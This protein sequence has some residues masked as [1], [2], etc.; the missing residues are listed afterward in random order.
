MRDRVVS[1][2]LAIGRYTNRDEAPRRPKCPFTRICADICGIRIAHEGS[3]QL[4]R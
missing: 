4:A 1:P 2:S 3:T